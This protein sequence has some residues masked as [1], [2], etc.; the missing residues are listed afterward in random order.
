MIKAT[1]AVSG[2]VIAERIEGFGAEVVA[3]IIGLDHRVNGPV[4]LVVGVRIGKQVAENA[5]DVGGV[6]D[7]YGVIEC[8]AARPNLA[9]RIIDQHRVGP[10]IVNVAKKRKPA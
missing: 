5:H 9:L 3:E 8:V 10:T 7:M 4:Q 6:H 2:D 1:A